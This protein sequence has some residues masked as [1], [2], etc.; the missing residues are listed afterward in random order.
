MVTDVVVVAIIILIAC[1]LW[2]RKRLGRKTTNTGN[3]RNNENTGYYD[4]LSP[5]IQLPHIYPSTSV[6]EQPSIYAQLD[7]CRRVPMDA[8]YSLEV[9]RDAALDKDFREYPNTK[10]SSNKGSDVPDQTDYVTVN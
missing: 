1:M 4:I 6:Y 5:Q 8:N 9:E 3:I 7:S 10:T 2:K